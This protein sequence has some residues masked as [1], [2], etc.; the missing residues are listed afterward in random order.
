MESTQKSVVSETSMYT[1]LLLSIVWASDQPL[2]M[3][4]HCWLGVV[5]KPDGL[6]L[7]STCCI[8]FLYAIMVR[9]S[10]LVAFSFRVKLAG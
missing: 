6:L 4:S 10:T 1:W 5:L 3:H 7:N 9:L 8:F 2:Q